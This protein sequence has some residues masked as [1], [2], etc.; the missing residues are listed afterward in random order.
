[1]PR[2]RQE[3]VFDAI[4]EMLKVTP[5]WVGPIL[6]VVTFVGFRF[7]VPALIPAKQGGIDPG[8]LMRPLLDALA[9]I[10]AGAVLAAWVFAEIWKLGNRRLLDSQ[11]G[12]ASIRDA[13]WREFERLVSEAYRRRGYLAEVVGSDCGDG[14][15]DIRL[16]G[17]GETVL[18]QCKQRKAYKVG[19]TT[20]RELL[21]VVVSQ[22][23]DRGV[24]VTSGRFTR[25]ARV[26][27]GENRRIE[28][29]DGEQLA[30]LIR[31]VQ[32]SPGTVL[33][34]IP[35]AIPAP[36]Q[37]V[38]SCPLCGN[39]M[40]LRTAHRGKHAGS[41]FWGCQKYPACDGKRTIEPA[42]QY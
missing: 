38:P 12:L 13:T 28:L 20:V 35:A 27:A 6:V 25:E 7:V 40:V 39:Q 29:V 1:M 31:G 36:E 32:V 41:Q 18:V 9:W 34:P 19:V 14:G 15:V 23:A 21:G 16:N 2:R 37:P 30:E 33:P 22:K 11:S 5:A 17:H 10:F 42:R 4:G 26:F 24:V 3:S 8:L